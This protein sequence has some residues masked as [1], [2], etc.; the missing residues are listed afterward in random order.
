MRAWPIYESFFLTG[1]DPN[2]QPSI[3]AGKTLRIV[4]IELSKFGGD[5]LT[6]RRGLA[7]AAKFYVKI[8]TF[9]SLLLNIP[10]EARALCRFQHNEGKRQFHSVFRSHSGRQPSLKKP[11]TKTGF[12]YIILKPACSAV[13]S[14][15]SLLFAATRPRLK[16]HEIRP[17]LESV[18]SKIRWESALSSLRAV[19]GLCVEV[20]LGTWEPELFPDDYFSN[21][22]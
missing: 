9:F 1:N 7:A 10:R 8:N 6:V 22:K 15:G 16:G 14:D 19:G 21:G 20:S 18:S 13:G 12:P 2:P 5:P 11:E 17:V 3:L 4:E